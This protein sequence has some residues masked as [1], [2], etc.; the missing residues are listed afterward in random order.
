LHAT[1]IEAK[2]INVFVSA[3]WTFCGK[4]YEAHWHSLG[5]GRGKGVGHGKPLWLVDN[6]QYPD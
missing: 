6:T 5:S 4:L 3:A 1:K 2:F